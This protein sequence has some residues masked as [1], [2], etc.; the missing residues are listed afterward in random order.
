MQMDLQITARD[1]SL[2]AGEEAAVRR[3]AAKLEQ[4]YDR[5]T[6][7]RVL[8]ET[9]HR[10]PSGRGVAYAARVDLTVPGEE[11]VVTRRT[12]EQLLT[13]IQQAFDAAQRQVEDYVRRQRGAV[14]TPEVQ[15]H[16]RVSRLFR[17]EGYGF[18][19]TSDGREVYFHRNSVLHG[20]F[21]RLE[22][23]DEVRFEE[24]EGM[25]GPQAS[26]VAPVGKGRK[27]RRRARG[28]RAS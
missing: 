11:L 24:V 13:A 10:Y 5:I 8:I 25:K 21:D 22:T 1:L 23:G 15:P 6:G 26:T 4:F 27:Q 12:D 9:E 28:G 18:L 19:T 3:E 2:S 17:Y 20:G 7:C 14:K 16:G